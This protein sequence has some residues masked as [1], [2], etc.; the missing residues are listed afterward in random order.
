MNKV[1]VYQERVLLW[2]SD[3]NEPTRKME[4]YLWRH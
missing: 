1:I 4:E 2:D 3:S